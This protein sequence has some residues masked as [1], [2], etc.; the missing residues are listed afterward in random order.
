MKTL[1][2]ALL[3]LSPALAWADDAAVKVA[4]VPFTP[5]SGDVPNNAGSKAADVL[6][7]ALKGIDKLAPVDA[8]GGAADDPVARA[9]KGNEL[10]ASARKQL[11]AGQPHAAKAELEQALAELT[12]G[13][14]ALDDPEALADVEAALSRARF[15]TGDDA[16]GKAALLAAEA[17][18]PGKEFPETKSSSLFA[19]LAKKAQDEVLAADK[20]T[21]RISSIPPGAAARIDGLD[22]GRTPVV[23]KDLPPGPHHWRVDL[24]SG[25]STGGVF[26]V[27]GKS[28]GE[29]V[30]S[31]TGKG[32]ASALSAMVASNA[33][34]PDAAKAMKDAATGLDVPWVI[35]GGLH[36]DGGDL[37]LDAFVYSVKDGAF[38]RLPKVKFDADLVSAGQELTKIAN[39]VAGRVNAATLGTATA[40]PL[41]VSDGVAPGESVEVSEFRFPAPGTEVVPKKDVGPRKVIGGRSGPVKPGGK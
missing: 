16:G 30:G 36:G 23:V 34:G 28:K 1:A 13:A 7:T 2:A 31:A 27:K 11:D 40:L 25:Q 5:L 26:D 24:P 15:Q 41:K 12:A 6:V 21:L 18:H 37:V 38:A 22:A 33:L 35:F 4:V 29:V 3:V 14:A 19:G 39:D 17:L 32:P 9:K 10:L 20:G 8:A